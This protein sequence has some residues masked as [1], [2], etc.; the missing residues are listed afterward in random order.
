MEMKCGNCYYWEEGDCRR[1]P[2]IVHVDSEGKPST[3]WPSTSSFKWCGSWYRNVDA[4]KRQD[5]AKGQG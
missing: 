1:N 3:W 2:P 4:K 5:T